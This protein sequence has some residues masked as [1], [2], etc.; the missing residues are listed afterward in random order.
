MNRPITHLWICAL[1]S[2]MVAPS[3]QAAR[4]KELVKIKGVRSNPLLGYGLVV[5][6]P[7]S[8][9]SRRTLFTNQSLGSLL[10]RMGVNIPPGDIDVDNTAAVMVTAE[11]PPFANPGE[12][13]DVIVSAIGDARSLES[14]TL[15]LTPLKGANGKVY[16]VA[17]GPLTVGGF[18]ANVGRIAQVRR[19]SPTTGRI[20]GGATIERS[21][22]SRFVVENKIILHLNEADFTTAGRIAKAINT[23]S[24]D[25]AKADN[26]SAVTIT[27]PEPERASAVNFLAK[28]EEL[29]VA[30][31]VRARVV[32]NERTGTVVV[33]GLVTLSAAAVAHGNLNVSIQ[34]GFNVSQP[35]P[36]ARQGQTR[37]TPTGTAQVEEQNRGLK[38][39]PKTTTVDELVKAL[40]ALGASPRD[41]IAILQALKASGALRGELKVM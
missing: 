27:I 41:L 21:V 3:A 13:V 19:N 26:P 28:I 38:A 24:A 6:L 37:V 30:A 40:N 34:A 36:F 12:Q 32:V 2:M 25:I 31:D 39:I 23:L 17:Q 4:I 18:Q 7:G 16:G 15:L 1:L 33:G 35:A 14:G 22:P 11:L 9:D 20:T 10:R 29:D 5:G 8:G